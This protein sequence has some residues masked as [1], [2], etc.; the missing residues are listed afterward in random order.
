MQAHSH[1]TCASAT[2]GPAGSVLLLEP[3]LHVRTARVNMDWGPR[4]VTFSALTALVVW[5]LRSGGRT[6]PYL[7]LLGAVLLCT[8][9]CA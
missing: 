7:L 2:A 5:A 6:Q 4:A 3:G 1:C 9:T 8:R